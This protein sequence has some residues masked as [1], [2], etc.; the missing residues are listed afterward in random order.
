VTH[1]V[2]A[3]AGHAGGAAAA[4]LR[5]YG[6]GGD[7]TLV[8]EEPDLP[9]QRPPLSKGWLLGDAQLDDVT[10]RPA[11]FYEEN[12][13]ALQLGRRIT[14]LD[15]RAQCIHLDS[16]RNI[17][18]DR[19]VIASGCSPIW[20]PIPGADTDG[21]TVLRSV[22]D[23]ARL[24]AALGPAA[25]LVIIGG[26]YVGLEV[27]ASARLLGANVTVV[28]RAPRVLARVAHP[29]LSDLLTRIHARHGVRIETDRCVARIDSA[30]GSVHQVQLDD[31]RTIPCDTVLIGVGGQPN[32]A[33]ARAAGLVCDDGIVVDLQART[34]DPYI[35]AIGDV[36]RRPL[37]LYERMARLESVPNA[38]EQARQA[39]CAIT[40]RPAPAPEV[41]WQWSN[42]YDLKIQIAGYPYGAD[43]VVVRGNPEADALALFHFGGDRLLAVEAVNAPAEFMAGRQ[44][45]GRKAGLDKNK[46]ADLSLTMKQ[47]MN[48]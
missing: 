6:F 19:L 45:I 39:A 47:L 28:E 21:V 29:A 35:F 16:G 41:P 46:L 31:G 38:I 44:L 24:K 36:T 1:I 13:I 5:Q 9:Y 48:A 26:G 14:S 27:A 2:I 33:F 7:I 12:R 32:D 25:D 4:F 30:A 15:R 40:G 22:R 17:G 23:A 11:A 8:G 43:Q 42:Q 34:S 20:P 3:G 18:Y 10:L 37:P